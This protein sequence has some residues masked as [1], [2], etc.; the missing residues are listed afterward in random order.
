MTPLID[1]ECHCPY[2]VQYT[3]ALHIICNLKYRV[4]DVHA[5][6]HSGSNCDLILL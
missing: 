5:I 1:E 3:V 4:P 2:T 6:L